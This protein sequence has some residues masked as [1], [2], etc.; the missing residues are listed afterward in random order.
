MASSINPRGEAPVLRQ[1]NYET[2]PGGG[3]IFICELVIG[4]QIVRVTREKTVMAVNGS[5]ELVHTRSVGL[6]F[7]TIRDTYEKDE[8][9]QSQAPPVRKN[10]RFT[11]EVHETNMQWGGEIENF[12]QIWDD[13]IIP[14]YIC[15]CRSYQ[16]MDPFEYDLMRLSLDSF[17][18]DASTGLHLN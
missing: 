8:S 9:P 11:S 13:E 18:Y 10:F 6:N 16:N 12:M 17:D 14:Q 3:Y 5:Y 15:I 7:F 4:G 1:L 2:R